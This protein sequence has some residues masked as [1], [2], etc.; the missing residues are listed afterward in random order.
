MPG[1]VAIA[2]RPASTP[3]LSH[4]HTSLRFQVG[5]LSTGL[6]VTA[7]LY[8][9][10][11]WHQ[12][13][14]LFPVCF[15]W[16]LLLLK[17]LLA[18]FPL[19]GNEWLPPAQDYDISCFVQL[20]SVSVLSSNVTSAGC[21]GAGQR[22]EPWWLSTGCMSFLS[23]CFSK[24]IILTSFPQWSTHCALC[25][26][27]RLSLLK[28]DQVTSIHCSLL[29]LC[30]CVCIQQ[31]WPAGTQQILIPSTWQQM[32]GMAIHNPGQTVVPDS[33][34]GA[35]VSDSQQASGWRL[36]KSDGKLFSCCV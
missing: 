30:L 20:V 6:S 7:Q 31:G 11:A 22:W 36:V 21:L 1:V 14:F 8:G 23:V 18:H 2:V 29:N 19:S 26:S 12:T 33:P 35:P 28:L 32:P 17:S 3:S 5:C 4:S 9:M 16:Y 34:M 27:Y 15:V 13:P 10:H 25:P 24:N